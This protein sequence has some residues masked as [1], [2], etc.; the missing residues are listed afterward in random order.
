[1]KILPHLPAVHQLKEHT[2]FSEMVTTLNISEHVLTEWLNDQIDVIRNKI[3]NNEL[4]HEA[5]TRDKLS[6]L[7]FDQ[8][9]EKIHLFYQ[10]NLQG[11]INATGVVL[12]TNLGRA[13]LSKE[14]IDQMT[15]TASS[16]STLEYNLEAGKRG[17]RHDIV[18]E[19]ITQLTGAEAAIVVNNN[20]AAVYLVLKAI[21]TGREVIVSRGELVEI[22]G[23]FRISE[24]MEESQAELIDVGTSNKTHVND[25]VKAI[26]ENTGLL[27]KVHKSNFKVI[28]FTE[29]VHTD[30][31]INVSKQYHVPIYEDL[32]S[33]TLFDF[34]KN[35]I[36]TEPTVQEKI[37]AGIDILSFSGDKL[38][39]GPQAGIIV[40][41]NV[42]IDKLKKHQLA[43]VLRVDK[44]TLAGLEATLKAYLRGQEQYEIPT[45]H[46]ILESSQAILEKAH[47]FI[48]KI[49]SSQTGFICNVEAGKSIIGGGT[50]PDVEIDTYIV[51]VKHNRYKSTELAAKLRRFSV[52]IIVRLE[53][54]AVTLDFRTVSDEELDIVTEAFLHIQHGAS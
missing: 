29:E 38:L 11:V 24:I 51:N 46:D 21:A 27:M 18:E 9:D 20:A 42:F 1:M 52:P 32:G 12:H 8:L 45:I 13:R 14:A 47:K 15:H 4:N 23:S 48:E 7:I 30:E 31:L 33:G 36:G 6:E 54:E 22:G 19:Y 16:Y 2:R 5:L 53:N 26:T 17:S 28:G 43:R 40:G 39:G 34:Q 44:F 41:N 49:K 37:K 35:H 3:I 25:Y 10:N 50:M